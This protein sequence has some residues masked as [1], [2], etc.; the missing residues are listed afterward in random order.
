MLIGVR[1]WRNTMRVIERYFSNLDVDSDIEDL[2]NNEIRHL[3]NTG[4]IEEDNVIA[5]YSNPYWEET[6]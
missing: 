1:Q 3:I 2:N 6:P 4:I 5:Y